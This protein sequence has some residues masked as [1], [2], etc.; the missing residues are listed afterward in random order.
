MNSEDSNDLSVLTIV[1]FICVMIIYT[2]TAAT[3][4]HFKVI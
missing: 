4:E 1:I 3:L 2:I